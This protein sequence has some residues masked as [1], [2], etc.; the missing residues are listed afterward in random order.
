M[1]KLNSATA[2]QVAN[3]EPINSG[4]GDYP[5]LPDG[6]YLGRLREVTVRNDGNVPQ[7]SARYDH[8]HDL[9]GESQPGSLFA[10]LNLPVGKKGADKPSW[11][12][13]TQ[14]KWETYQR[15]SRGRLAAFFEGMGFTPDSDTDEMVGEWCVLVVGHH[16][17][18]TGK[19]Q[20]KVTNDV[21]GFEQV[22]EELEDLVQELESN[23]G[24]SD[25]DEY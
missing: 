20:G 16:T 6:K 19:N 10:N 17:I 24:G 7:W 11:Y 12:D 1:P 5:V 21:N 22:P 9:G 4:G 23:V 15:M 2:N 14:E 3:E 25:S 8:I 13:K 18:P